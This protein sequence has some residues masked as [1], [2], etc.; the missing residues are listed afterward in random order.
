[1]S[2]RLSRL[3]LAA[4]TASSSLLPCAT[5]WAQVGPSSTSVKK[6]AAKPKPKP[7]Q[8]DVPQVRVRTVPPKV[9]RAKPPRKAKPPVTAAKPTPK[10]PVHT[11]IRVKPPIRVPGP[12]TADAARRAAAAEAAAGKER[13]RIATT[14][15]KDEMSALEAVERNA[16]QLTPVRLDAVT[17]P[18][19]PKPPE[20]RQQTKY[21][22]KVTL[23]FVREDGAPF[24][25][26]LVSR[27]PSSLALIE[28]A[29]RMV[30]EGDRVSTGDALLQVGLP[31]DWGFV[32][33]DDGRVSLAD[34]PGDESVV[35]MPLPG[36]G[37]SPKFQP[38]ERLWASA[39][40]QAAAQKA[41][42]A[43][44]HHSV[45]G[46][47]YGRPGAAALNALGTLAQARKA[48]AGVTV[49]TSKTSRLK[50]WTDLEHV[51]RML[52]DAGVSLGEARV[53]A[54]R[55]DP[56]LPEA[57]LKGE[58][59]ADYARVPD[60]VALG[61]LRLAQYSAEAEWL[62]A[63]ALD[64][65]V[66]DRGG[67]IKLLAD[68]PE[69]LV[70]NP[71]ISAQLNRYRA[72]AEAEGRYR[73]ALQGSLNPPGKLTTVTR[74][75]LRTIPVQ[76]MTVEV[77][78]PAAELRPGDRVTLA[79]A[80]VDFQMRDGF[81]TA[82]LP[83]TAVRP[84]DKLLVKRG[85]AS[86]ELTLPRLDAY[87][88]AGNLLHAPDLKSVTVA[89]NPPVNPPVEPMIPVVPTVPTG[90]RRIAVTAGPLGEI[91]LHRELSQDV[92]RQLRQDGDETDEKD[93][94][95]WITLRTV[96]L[97]LKLQRMAGE[98]APDGKKKKA[99]RSNRMQVVA[100]RM[101]GPTAGEVAGVRVGS[102]QRSAEAALGM[103]VERSG[104]TPA[105]GGAVQFVL[106]DGI[107]QQ[108]LVNRELGAG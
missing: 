29:N 67:A 7:S 5:A 62:R 53:A 17:A 56:S 86:G 46:V 89:V 9:V 34:F 101:E 88:A 3:L 107:V 83:R 66:P 76:K 102:S 74:S 58:F 60:M 27:T 4:L 103:S 85:E 93:G 92:L 20:A 68:L 23:V 21:R 42:P 97:A 81:W 30:F 31:Q 61:E 51:Q 70:R 16:A 19:L 98:A 84:G 99:E 35:E 94:T 96:P 8:P 22:Q 11:V 100:A 52:E 82:R 33:A 79:N 25:G 38:S 75:L 95:S 37:N 105:F 48:L 90:S 43:L 49:G 44:E 55:F 104:T 77:R 10:P 63:Q 26:A 45:T 36:G 24:T 18:L 6:P 41:V 50:A 2:P 91:P 13:L 1:M 64:P 65:S 14:W 57:I 73:T 54:K 28:T 108:I 69:A 72:V 59:H 87:A 39:A 71:E 40:E 32:K 80:V 47:P 12:D 78:F 15:Q 106:R